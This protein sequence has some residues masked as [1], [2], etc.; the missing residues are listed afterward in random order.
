NARVFVADSPEKRQWFTRLHGTEADL[1]Q[2]RAGWVIN[3]GRFLNANDVEQGAQ[4]MVLGRV[5]ADRLFGEGVEPTGKAVTLWNQRFQVIGVVGSKSWA[6]QPVAGDDQFDAVYVPVTTVHRLL[7]LSKLNTV[8]VTTTSV[9]ENAAVTKQIIDLLR[10][11][12]G[13]TEAQPDDFIV[14]SMAKQAL[15][16]GLPPE[17][18]RAVG[19]NLERIEELTVEQLSGSLSRA[20]QT[21][22]VMLGSVAAVSL[23]VGG[24]GVTNLLLLS[25]TQR[26]REVGLR[27]ALGARQSDIAAQFLLEAVL[28]SLIGGVLGIAIGV[29]ASGGLESFFHWSA[30]VS[31]LTALAAIAAALVLGIVAGVYPARRA[32]ELR[33]IEALRHE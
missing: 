1:P 31:P 11:R 21:M 9:G 18:A 29:A 26:T 2:V 19:G 23:L 20:N 17:L 15:G 5:V 13:I 30:T 10:E 33:P 27:I 24:I 7:N 12:H 22:L 16:K 3:R 32:S 25:V 6:S 28:L 8:T 4:V 14:T